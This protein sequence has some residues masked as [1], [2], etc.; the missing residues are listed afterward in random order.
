MSC[1]PTLCD[2]CQRVSLQSA[3]SVAAGPVRCS[4][5]NEPLRV[6]PSRSYSDHDIE[7]FD[8]LSQTVGGNLSALEAYRLSVELDNA[9]TSRTWDRML[10]ALVL[11]WP[12]LVPQLVF[13]GV[14]SARQRRSLQMLKTIFDAFSLTRRSGTMLGAA[15]MTE[16]SSPVRVWKL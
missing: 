14:D 3:Q 12:G 10:E 5:C 16:S 11:R 2:G 8:D 4:V 6:V 15:E 9:L 7:S 13:V 1:V